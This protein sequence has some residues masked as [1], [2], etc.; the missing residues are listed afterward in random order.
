[1]YL[2]GVAD[3]S[4]HGIA[5]VDLT[6]NDFAPVRRQRILMLD[7]QS[8]SIKCAAVL[9]LRTIMHSSAIIIV[10]VHLVN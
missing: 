2:V 6:I 3:G 9:L 5:Q 4:V 1:M 8:G 7:G 10:I